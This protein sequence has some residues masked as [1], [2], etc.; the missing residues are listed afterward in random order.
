MALTTSIARA[1]GCKGRFYVKEAGTF[2]KPEMFDASGGDNQ[3]QGVSL[4]RHNLPLVL[5]FAVI[6]A[7]N[8]ATPAYAQRSEQSQVTT[9]KT[10]AAKTLRARRNAN[11]ASEA[12]GQASPGSFGAP[13]SN[14]HAG[15]CFIAV[16]RDLDLGYWGS[17]DTRGARPVK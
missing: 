15:Q 11:D 2:S 7:L 4:M 12:Y 5:G 1:A 16:D 6:T 13:I 17:C 14:E 10:G 8:F 9:S 3:H